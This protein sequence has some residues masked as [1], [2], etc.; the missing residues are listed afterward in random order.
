MRQTRDV[1]GMPVTIDV[2]DGEVAAAA[3]DAAFAWLQRVDATFSTYRDDSQVSR[4]DRGEL[5]EREAA[6]EVREVL[7]ACRALR[8]RTGGAFDARAG[9]RLDPS[10]YVKG[11][12]IGRAWDVLA[13]AGARNGVVDAG[14]DILARGHAPG[15]RRWRVGIRH[16]LE[17]DRLAAV[18]V[19][20]D[21]AVATSGTYRRGEHI[22]DPRTGAAP[23]GV[24]SV[25]CAGADIATADALATA[26]FAMG[27]GAAAW[28]ARQPDVESMVVGDDEVVRTT[29]GFDALRSAVT[30]TQ[31]DLRSSGAA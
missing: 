28:L 18:L 1:M 2:R 17:L 14:G 16:P 21:L 27:S 12:A 20:S 11:W 9:G 10:G 30:G 23:R 24:L 15:G 26:A 25:T 6:P 13:A 4:M 19:V 29:P 7:R 22:V 3:I 8:V 31:P 5:T